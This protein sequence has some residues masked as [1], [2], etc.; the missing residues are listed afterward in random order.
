LQH[1]DQPHP[2]GESWREA[3]Q[4][5]AGSLD[6]FPDRWRG[7]RVLLVGHVATRWGLD[8]TLAGRASE[9]LMGEPVGWQPCWEYTLD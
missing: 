1:L 5:V 2:P 9:D 8:V 4:R 7:R 6:E 3:V